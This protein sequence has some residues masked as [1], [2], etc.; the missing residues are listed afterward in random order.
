MG[1]TAL[2]A[3]F[4]GPTWSPPGSCRPHV[5]PR[6]PHESCYLGGISGIA[7]PLCADSIDRCPFYSHRVKS[8]DFFVASWIIFWTNSGVVGDLRRLTAHMTPMLYACCRSLMKTNTILSML[9]HTHTYIYIYIYSDTI[10]ALTQSLRLLFACHG[11]LNH[12]WIH[13]LF[14]SFF[15]LTTKKTPNLCISSTVHKVKRT[16]FPRHNTIMKM[17][18]KY[19]DDNLYCIRQLRWPRIWCCH[20]LPPGSLLTLGATESL[21]YSHVSF[22]LI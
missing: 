3:R 10:S 6:R 14:N 1:S 21:S 2:I 15:T 7:G 17:L 13:C 11:A 12:R 8:V 5:G 9:T 16:A 4:M 22:N 19:E 18:K 20:Y